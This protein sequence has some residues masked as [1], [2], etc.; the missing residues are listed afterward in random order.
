MAKK[1]ELTTDNLVPWI[2]TLG[3][4][5]LLFVLYSVL[6]GKGNNALGWLKQIWRFGK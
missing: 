1:G 5:V 4:I 2:I 3:V 6:S